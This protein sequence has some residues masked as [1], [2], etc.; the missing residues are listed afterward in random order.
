MPTSA[1]AQVSHR[2]HRLLEGLDYVLCSPAAA[3]RAR[4]VVA[5]VQR[6]CRLRQQYVEDG[7]PARPAAWLCH[8]G[9]RQPSSAG[10]RLRH[11]RDP[12]AGGMCWLGMTLVRGG[13][14]ARGQRPEHPAQSPGH[15]IRPGC[16]P[17]GHGC[18][19]PSML[20]KAPC[21]A[22]PAWTSRKPPSQTLARRHLLLASRARKGSVGVRAAMQTADCKGQQ[23]QVTALLP[24]QLQHQRTC[25][26][27]RAS[28]RRAAWHARWQ[29]RRTAAPTASRRWQ[30]RTRLVPACRAGAHRC[31]AICGHARRSWVKQ[32]LLGWSRAGCE[33]GAGHRSGT[34]G[35]TPSRPCQSSVDML[36]WGGRA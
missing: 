18:A 2:R 26:A 9:G 27:R 24:T 15:R 20:N 22:Q 32:E 25:W 19:S 8:Q 17:T 30:A 11:A 31:P 23:P 7:E 29:K 10:G 4:H 3:H 33:Q 1:A 36:G 12:E 21:W 34:N 28:A 13:A 6:L 16:P 14:Q 35:T 5:R